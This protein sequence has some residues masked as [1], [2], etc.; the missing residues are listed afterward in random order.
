MKYVTTQQ[1]RDDFPRLI[2]RWATVCDAAPALN[3]HWES[4]SFLAGIIYVQIGLFV[5]VECLK[6][7]AHEETPVCGY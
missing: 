6:N 4:F 3:K 1:R 7:V 2:Q 5:A